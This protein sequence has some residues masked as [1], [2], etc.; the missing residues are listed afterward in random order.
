MD[1][2]QAIAAFVFGVVFLAT[3]ILLGICFPNPTSFQLL[4][5][6]VVL[7]LAAAGVAAM[8]PGFITLNFSPGGELAIR[9][10]G[11][12]SLFLLVFFFNGAVLPGS[13]RLSVAEKAI[14]YR[15]LDLVSGRIPGQPATL[16]ARVLGLANT[17]LINLYNKLL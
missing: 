6:R 15:H 16:L 11:A 2:V 9:A 7:G 12:T 14:V 3:A 17:S 1:L 8:I 10:G 5:F 4:I 13:L